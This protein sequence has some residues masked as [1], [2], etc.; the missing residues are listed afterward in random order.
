MQLIALAAQDDHASTTPLSNRHPSRRNFADFFSQN[1]MG[2]RKI[3]KA[4]NNVAEASR[5]RHRG[6]SETRRI[7]HLSRR[8]SGHPSY[9]R[10][11]NVAEASRLRPREESEAGRICHFSRGNSEQPSYKRS[12]NVAEAA[13]LRPRENQKQDASATF[14]TQ[15]GT[16]LLQSES[17]RS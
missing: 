2:A 7:F 3:L 15:F 17:Q 10:T 9:K 11:H 16:P 1:S 5:L 4:D 6:K 14:S 12:H 8:N 13:R